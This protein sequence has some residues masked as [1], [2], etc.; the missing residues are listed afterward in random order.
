MRNPKV[1][2]VTGDENRA[3]YHVDQTLG[4]T[5]RP[6]G[7][8]VAIH[9][10]MTRKQITEVGTK[11]RINGAPDASSADP[12]DLLTPS[13]LGKRLPTPAAHSGMTRQQ[14]AAALL[15]HG[16]AV[17]AEGIA[18]DG[19]CHSANMPKSQTHGF[20]GQ[21]LPQQTNEG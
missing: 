12:R 14:V 6:K 11:H 7:Y 9:P 20:N 2:E 8:D 3:P 19:P 1:H 16:D 10:G 15:D 18:A 5:P 21:R 4:K 17:I 13:Q